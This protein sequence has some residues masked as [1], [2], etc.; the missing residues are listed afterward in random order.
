MNKILVILALFLMSFTPVSD[1]VVDRLN[2]KGP[3]VYDNTSYKL[4][5]SSHPQENYYIQEYL[6]EGESQTNFNQMLTVCCFVGDYSV[7]D[8]AGLMIRSLDKRK[9]TDKVCNYILNKSPDGK[10]YILDYLMGESK[11]NEM[12]TAEFGVKFYKKVSLTN[13]KKAI[14]IYSYIK[15]SYGAAITNM[16]KSLRT[17]RSKIINTMIASTKPDVSIK[18]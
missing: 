9:K 11:G 8:V 15:R 1:S 18:N 14:L 2:M 3:I 6:P 10:K 4:T 16:L 17:D 13:G 7:S 12:T 5:W